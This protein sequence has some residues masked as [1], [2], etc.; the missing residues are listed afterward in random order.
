MERIFDLAIRLEGG[1]SARCVGQITANSFMK[2]EFGKPVP[3]KYGTGDF[4]SKVMWAMRGKLDVPKERFMSCPGIERSTDPTAVVG[5]GGGNHQAQAQALAALYSRGPTSKAGRP[6]SSGRC[7]PAW[8]SWCPA[9]ASGTT[10][11]TRPSARASATT[12]P[13]SSPPSPTASAS[14]PAS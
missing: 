4:R 11:S 5:L 14:A 3:P 7:S 2:R 13:T 1:E 9:C 12:S 8:P 10:A 6:P